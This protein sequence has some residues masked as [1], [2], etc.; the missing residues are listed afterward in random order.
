MLT[1]MLPYSLCEGFHDSISIYEL[2]LESPVNLFPV[3]Q[4]PQCG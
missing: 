1:A 2:L 3:H 4:L